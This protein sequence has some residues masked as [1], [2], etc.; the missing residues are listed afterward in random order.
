[1]HLFI[2][3]IVQVINARICAHRFRRKRWT[4]PRRREGFAFHPREAV[5]T[6]WTPLAALL[7]LILTLS[8][9]NKSKNPIIS[10][11]GVSKIS[12]PGTSLRP[13]TGTRPASTG[14]TLQEAWGELVGMEAP[15]GA[16]PA[17][18][19]ELRVELGSALLA[20][21]LDRFP[22]KAP[23]QDL[24]NGIVLTVSS[25]GLTWNEARAGD[26]NNDGSIS[27]QDLSPL[28]F[29]LGR[30]SN[31][32]SPNYYK[33]A[34]FVDGNG[35]TLVN[36][37]DITPIALHF[38]ESTGGY[39]VYEAT[40]GTGEGALKV[41]SITRPA[42]PDDTGNPPLGKSLATLNYDTAM[43]QVDPAGW[44]P[45]E[46][47]WYQVV[48]F[49]GNT[50]PEES[51]EVNSEW[52]ELPVSTPEN[53]P[54]I[55]RAG[56]SP[57]SG[58]VPLT[59][60]FSA[61][62]SYDPDGA[63]VLYEWD[64]DDDG[65]YDSSSPTS[66]FAQHTYQDAGGYA[67]WLRV[68]DDKGSSSKAYVTIAAFPPLQ[69]PP[70]AVAN[71]FPPMGYALLRVSFTATGSSD[72]NGPISL[73]EWD[74]TNDG[75][76]D[77][78]NST[79]Y[80]THTYPEGV[81]IARLR[82]TDDTGLT[83]YDAVTITSIAGP[84]VWPM[85]GR[86]PTHQRRSPVSGPQTSKIKWAY[87][88]VAAYTSSPAI[89]TDGTI[90]V[91]A[92]SPVQGLYRFNPDGTLKWFYQLDKGSWSTPAI[93][94]DGT[95][96]FGADDQYIY[97][98]NQDGSLRWKHF[99]EGIIHSS[100]TIA[101]DGTVYIGNSDHH[102]YAL[103]P[104]G[105]LKWRYDAGVP[106]YSSPA[107]AADGSVYAEVWDSSNG[108][109]KMVALN[110]DGTVKWSYDVEP[111]HGY[112]T[113]PSIGDDGTVYFGSSPQMFSGVVGFLYALSPNGT[114][115]W[116]YQFGNTITGVAIA[117]DD[118]LYVGCLDGFLYALNPDGTFKWSFQVEGSEIGPHIPAIGADG[119]VYFGLTGSYTSLL[120][121]GYFYAV[122]PDGT[123]KWRFDSTTDWFGPPAIDQD[124]SLYVL[125][126]FGLL[127]T[128]GMWFDN[129][130]P[131][132]VVEATPTIGFPPLTVDLN[133]AKSY[134]PDGVIIKY[135]WDFLSD[136]TIDAIAQRVQI[137]F[138]SPGTYSV[139]LYVTDNRLY[140]SSDSVVIIVNSPP[141]AVAN[142]DPDNGPAP[143]TVNFSA[144]GSYDPDGTIALYEWD[145]TDDGVYDYSNWTGSCLYTY[146]DPGDYTAR[147][148]VTD[149]RGATATDTVNISVYA[150]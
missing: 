47:K 140:K 21:E 42:V 137:G 55:A 111:G 70:V 84:G 96:Y 100:T 81:F 20:R 112:V 77:V 87:P 73:Y 11:P 27:A 54:P 23:T 60:N 25:A 56:A 59:V 71:A 115:K 143:L 85:Y 133:G 24:M 131:V 62:G 95:V 66:A 6:R 135:E 68:T 97:A 107:V 7:F 12:A 121:K 74:F 109:G 116:R 72:P 80:T 38:G 93:G 94:S 125:G 5:W 35:D 15:E 51:T 101:S 29:Y 120:D 75:Q 106:L 67:A 9:C 134:D 78:A 53:Q 150:P 108:V 147:L 34:E 103:T 46:G 104:E 14:I 127:Y 88:L 4:L 102:L 17:L 124:G 58:T 122:K 139:T 86:D 114:L 19:A 33:Y 145:Y 50:P 142:A 113:S 32:T 91:A 30:S 129:Q 132:A 65:T 82:V 136:G 36:A 117:D 8:S 43:G 16:D 3:K 61:S 118:T 141:Q 57:K 83:D 89:A 110:P 138:A 18:F 119:T 1:M 26:W 63:I 22:S 28:A 40:D 130:P 149:N 99:T 76:F 31:P 52:V 148:R 64:F 41:A 39:N 123:L 128:F 126:A 13:E 90:Y 48:P 10:Q 69:Q 45:V 49:D 144:T 79:G 37:G 105:D 92:I 2:V 44:I 98:L 146:T